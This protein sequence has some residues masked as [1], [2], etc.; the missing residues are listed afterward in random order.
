M[1][2]FATCRTQLLTENKAMPKIIPFIHLSLFGREVLPFGRKPTLLPRAI[3]CI[4][5][6]LI[7]I[8]V[9]HYNS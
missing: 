7:C 8:R 9:I 3:M 2:R 6:H 5:Q 4:L 1:A